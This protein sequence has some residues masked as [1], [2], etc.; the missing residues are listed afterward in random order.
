MRR[1]KDEAGTEDEPGTAGGDAPA[2]SGRK[3]ALQ[4]SRSMDVSPTTVREYMKKWG[5]DD[6]GGKKQ[7][8]YPPQLI[9]EWDR[10]HERYGKNV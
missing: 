10:L 6:K 4:I 1:I 7:G 5:L 8:K 3:N 2:G 9:A